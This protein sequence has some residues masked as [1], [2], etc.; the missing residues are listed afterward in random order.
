MVL[1]MNNAKEAMNKKS[2][3]EE[4]VSDSE[5]DETRKNDMK[6]CMQEIMNHVHY[7]I[8]THPPGRP[9]KHS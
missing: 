4:E 5:T 6:I 8:I 7:N 1:N 9:K 3:S 2:N